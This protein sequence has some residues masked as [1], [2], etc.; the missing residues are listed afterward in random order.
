MAWQL[1]RVLILSLPAAVC[2]AVVLAGL[3]EV[4]V[5]DPLAPLDL[6]ALCARS[7]H[8]YCGQHE[9]A[10]GVLVVSIEK[11]VAA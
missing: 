6:E 7:G 10:D 8:R 5:T 1:R 4:W 2:A 11:R 9:R 3:I